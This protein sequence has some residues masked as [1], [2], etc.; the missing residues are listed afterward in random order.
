MQFLKL[1]IALLVASAS[2]F[3]APASLKSQSALRSSDVAMGPK[4]K[5]D[6]S[7]FG[8]SEFLMSGRDGK[9]ELLSGAT[10]KEDVAKRFDITYDTRSR[11]ASKSSGNA[12]SG[13]I[14]PKDAS[15][16]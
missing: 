7:P 12:K 16:W 1:C 4:K 11:T 14:N 10:R 5:A 8:L 15:T 2:A 9:L 3:V 6:S 13:T